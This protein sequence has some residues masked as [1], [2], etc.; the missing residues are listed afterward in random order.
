MKRIRKGIPSAEE[1]LYQGRGIMDTDKEAIDNWI[2]TTYSTENTTGQLPHI[3]QYS[4]NQLFRTV[5]THGSKEL[6]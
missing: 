5:T 1:V 3:V 4:H 6:Q 2:T